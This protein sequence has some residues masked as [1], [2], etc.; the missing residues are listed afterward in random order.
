MDKVEEVFQRLKEDG[1]IKIAKNISIDRRVPTFEADNGMFKK[2]IKYNNQMNKLS[3]EDIE[4]G[5]LHEEGHF[6]YPYSK[7]ETILLVWPALLFL[8]IMLGFSLKNELLSYLVL[9]GATL[10]FFFLCNLHK[11]FRE[12]SQKHEYLADEFAF[13]NVPNPLNRLS[14]F[15][16]IIK[17][18]HAEK[19]RWRNYIE[20]TLGYSHSHPSLTERNERIKRIFQER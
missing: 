15:D 17:R 3:E 11:W 14:S 8:L 10:M 19:L 7:K 2:T 6:R 12:I 4:M 9:L 16:R 13:K 1:R 5:L 20:I 18:K